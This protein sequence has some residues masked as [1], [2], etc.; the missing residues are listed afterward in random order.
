[1]RA[2]A[3]S[4]AAACLAVAAFLACAEHPTAP[5]ASS[6]LDGQ[7][8][9]GKNDNAKK[10]KDRAALLTNVPV[11]GV[12]SDGG[13]FTGTFTAQHLAVDEATRALTI[14]GRLVGTAVTAAGV[15]TAIDQVVSAPATLTRAASADA[16]LVHPV[17]MRA[18]CDILFLDLGPLNLDVLGL[19]VDLAEVILDINAVS[20]AG[21][22]LGNLLCAVVGLLDLPGF[23]AGLA[24]LIDNINAILEGL[25]GLGGAASFVGPNVSPA[26]MAFQVFS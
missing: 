25:G 15:S 7:S 9:A 2:R 3:L 26:A 21:N 14:T 12:L 22:L 20:G 17:A 23:I 10:D 4:L 11:S 6:Q 13:T 19:T 24:Q 16:A 18:V 5:N 1:M 8:P